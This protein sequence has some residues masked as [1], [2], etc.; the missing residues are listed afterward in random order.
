MAIQGRKDSLLNKW[1]QNKWT[2]TCKKRNLDR[3][4]TLHKNSKWIT[5]LSVKCKTIKLTEVNTGE[6]LDDLEFEKTFQEQH[7]N[8][9]RNN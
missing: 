8:Q 5:N 4:Y 1:C 6:N 3:Y 9:E 2:S 7:M